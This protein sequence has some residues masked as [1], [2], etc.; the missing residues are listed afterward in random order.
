MVAKSGG[1]FGRPFKW[2]RSVKQGGPLFPTIFNVAIDAIIGHWLTVVTP[3]ETDT[4]GL[5]LTIIDLAAYF[6]AKNGLVLS[7]QPERL[8]RYFDVLVGLFDRVSL[9]TNISKTVGMACHPCHAPGG[10]SEES[11]EKR[12]TG[13]EPTFW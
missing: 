10:M 9:C 1:Y 7:T 5:V 8:Q 3:T 11:Y 4:G 6:Y 2:Y 13:K 12:T